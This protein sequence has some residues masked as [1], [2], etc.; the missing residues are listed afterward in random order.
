MERVGARIRVG[1]LDTCRGGSWTQSK[2][3]SVGPPL[4]M[5]D[6]MNVDT[7]GT[8]LVSSSSGIENAHEALDV[9]GSFFTHYLAAGLRGAADQ[10]GDG[11]V[12]LAEAFDYAK[13]RTVRDSARLAT[14]PQ[15][16]S[17]DLQLRGRQDIVLT[18]LAGATSALQ[19]NGKHPSLEVIH[20][21]S[22]VTVADAPNGT[23]ALRIA[24]PPGRYLVRSV[25]DGKVYAK[26]IEV[27]DGETATLAEGQ[28]V[29]TGSGELAMKGDAPK[30]AKHDD[31]DDDAE[32]KADAAKDKAEEA[33]DKAEEEKE[34]AEEKADEAKEKAEE[35]ADEA[36]EKAE[37][38][39][40]K[41]EKEA[42]R[43]RREGGELHVAVPQV[44][45]P[46]LGGDDPRL[47][48][49]RRPSAAR[50]RRLRQHRDDHAGHRAR[51]GGRRRGVLA[52]RDPDR[53]SA[54]PARAG[55]RRRRAR[56]DA[57]GRRRVGLSRARDRE[58][59]ARAS[60]RRGGTRDGRQRLLF[61]GPRAAASS[62][63]DGSGRRG[64]RSSRRR[65]PPASS[66][67]GSSG[68]TTR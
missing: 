38:A 1:I 51:G 63:R 39:R 54:I 29:A 62:R 65:L 53:D 44:Q 19:V 33:Q 49:L 52:A 4:R 23:T 46:R 48:G 66:S 12:T 47:D 58:P 6:L 21:P 17:F 30:P 22:G 5:A 13:E 42:P 43:A 10:T 18:T 28:L 2:G 7:E 60:R 50:E 26:E 11:N 32:S 8:A 35:K 59:G 15:H 57:H 64:T 68:R 3:L 45:R 20:L 36:K 14:M 61:V 34:A 16:P 24:V 40:E 27:R 31:D 9:H 37:E 67:P 56:R 41:A 25:V 55:R